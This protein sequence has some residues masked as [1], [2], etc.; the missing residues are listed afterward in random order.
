MLKL[1]L[2]MIGLTLFAEVSAEPIKDIEE[3][4][5]RI[6]ECIRGDSHRECLNKLLLLHRHPND[7]FLEKELSTAITL[8]AAVL[9][10]DKIY[11]IHPIKTEKVGNLY[12]RRVQVVEGYEFGFTVL[13]ISY[14]RLRGDL[15]LRKFTFSRGGKALDA[16]FEGKL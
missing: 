13:E 10:N 1:L 11:E 12:E 2:L 5:F 9:K 6:N 14:V 15:Y 8:L 7:P 16:L 3:F 4:Q